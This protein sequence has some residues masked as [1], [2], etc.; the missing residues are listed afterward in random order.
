MIVFFNRLIKYVGR[1]FYGFWSVRC[2]WAPVRGITN[3]VQQSIHIQGHLAS[4]V[5]SSIML[6]HCECMNYEHVSGRSI[7]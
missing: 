5:N 2:G 4:Y 3:T 1:Y 7:L 6:F